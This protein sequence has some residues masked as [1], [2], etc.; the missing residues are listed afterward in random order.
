MENRTGVNNRGKNFKKESI[1]LEL[2]PRRQRGKDMW[3]VILSA[4]TIG[5]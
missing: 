3:N 2:M 4:R 1:K 5:I